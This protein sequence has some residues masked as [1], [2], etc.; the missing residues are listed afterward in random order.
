[1]RRP[2][3]TPDPIAVPCSR[4]HM[5]GVGRPDPGI[6]HA[7]PLA[8]TANTTAMPPQPLRLAAPRI[9]PVGNRRGS[10]SGRSAVP[11]LLCLGTPP[12]YISPPRRPAPAQ[13]PASTDVIGVLLTGAA[14]R[15]VKNSRPRVVISVP[16]E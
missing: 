16:R 13:H 10:D 2:G 14:G 6:D 3:V 12:C 11:A 8:T 9:G 4:R 7:A 15:R 1:M 5:P